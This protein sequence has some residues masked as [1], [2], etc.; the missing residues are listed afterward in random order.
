MSGN[1][2]WKVERRNAQN[3]LEYSSMKIV[4]GNWKEVCTKYNPLYDEDVRISPVKTYRDDRGSII[5]Y[6][7]G[8]ELER[9]NVRL[10][11]EDVVR[12]TMDVIEESNRGVI[13]MINGRI[14]EASG[15]GENRVEL[16]GIELDDRERLGYYYTK[17]GYNFAYMNGNLRLIW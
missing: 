11:V 7:G 13:E 4:E 6:F 9:V 2:I 16:R 8:V 1:N 3:I 17:L 10:G 5:D 14:R 12:R 15:E